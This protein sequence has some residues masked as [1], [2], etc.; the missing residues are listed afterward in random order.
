MSNKVIMEDSLFYVTDA[1]GNADQQ[2]EAGHGLYMKDT[3]FLSHYQLRVNDELPQLLGSGSSE[4]YMLTTL[5]KHEVK[6]VG[7]IELKRSSFIHDGVLHEQL[8]VTNYFLTSQSIKLTL[9]F[10]ADFQDMFIVRRYRTGE[11]GERLETVYRNNSLQLQYMG[12]DEQLRRT[13]VYWQSEPIVH[14]QEQ[15]L[16]YQLSL[17]AGEHQLIELAIV[18]LLGETENPAAAASIASYSQALQS[19]T[20]SYNRWLMG[21]TR[22]T[23]SNSLFN[24]LYERS[25]QDLRMLQIDIGHGRTTVAGLPWFATVFGRDSLITS[26]FMLPL[27]PSHALGTLRTLAAYQGKT[28]DP[29]RDEERGKIMHEIRFGELVQTGQSPFSPYYGG[30]DSTP[31]FLV[32]LVE[33]VKWSGDTSIVAELQSAIDAA[34]DWIDRRSQSNPAGFLT[35]KQEA[36]QGFPNQ[37]WKDSANSIVHQEGKLAAAPI[38]LV[39]VQGYICYAKQGLSEIYESLKQRERSEQ[40]KRQAEQLANHIEQY[41]WLEEEQYF[42]I[43][44]DGE[45]K[46]VRSITSNPGHLL[47]ASMLQPRLAEKLGERLLAEDMFTGFGIRT[48]SSLS[49]GYYPMSYHNGSVWP[50]DNGMILLGC[51]RSGRFKEARMI[52]SGLLRTAAEVPE[53]RF[54]ELFCG[55]SK[56]ECDRLVPYPTTCSPQAWSAA[57]A[58]VMLQSMLGLQVDLLQ[59]KISLTPGLPLDIQELNVVG[60][61]IGSGVLD[62]YVYIDQETDQTKATILNNTTGFEVVVTSK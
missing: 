32:L 31:L 51:L 30:V 58:F 34:L 47:L 4:S 35:Y 24:A 27:H 19:L 33:Y 61:T 6:D 15:M 42:S 50:H 8:L 17:A 54:P 55:Y 7:A 26:L 2:Q 48:M 37:G 38:A 43:A 10:D 20:Q 45:L 60:L 41:F 40:L 1:Y 22:V 39:E 3:R 14:Q 56:H 9:Q 18:P 5:L 49:T 28:N 44:L 57:T 23:S 16:E 53:Q 62:I 59:Q 29:W 21:N 13:L 36:E 52:V 11:V 12:R 25:L 46:P